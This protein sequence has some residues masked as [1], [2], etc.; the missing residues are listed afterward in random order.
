MTDHNNSGGEAVIPAG[1]SDDYEVVG[2]IEDLIAL[3]RSRVESQNFRLQIASQAIEA[4]AL[5]DQ[6]QYRK[7]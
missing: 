1:D 3:E 5:A 4:N 2:P 7:L 6:R